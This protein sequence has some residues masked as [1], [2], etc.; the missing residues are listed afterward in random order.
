MAVT[1]EL[2][3]PIAVAR[4]NL[5]T[6]QR[7]PLDEEKRERLVK[8][9]LDE[10]ARLNFLT[11][12]ILV[13][14][15]L[16]G[17]S[18]R[19][20]RNELN[21]AGLLRDCIRDFQKRFPN[22]ELIAHMLLQIL[23]NNLLENA[24]KYAPKDSP[25]QLNLSQESTAIRLE[26]IDQGPG[27]PRSERK[28]IFERFYRIENETTRKTAGTGLGLY[29]CKKIAANHQATISVS[30]HLPRGSNFAVVFSA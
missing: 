30:D 17:Q 3:T 19:S 25:I 14:S 7:Y 9:T 4:L 12:N 15:Q 28:Q 10:T 16:A 23:V 2:K 13:A 11:N 26:V 6:I 21:L 8:T 18:F 24:Q 1:H 22:R 5:E 27:I 20:E 29:L